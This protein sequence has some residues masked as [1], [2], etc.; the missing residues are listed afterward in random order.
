MGPQKKQ[1]AIEATLNY[2]KAATDR[3]KITRKKVELKKILK[4][5]EKANLTTN[6]VYLEAR[7]LVAELTAEDKAKA[8][9]KIVL[10]KATGSK[11]L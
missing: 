4:D 3:A 9:E 1:D 2:L 10:E 5:A 6:R 7:G 8:K 11:S